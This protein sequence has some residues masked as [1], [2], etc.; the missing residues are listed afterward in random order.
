MEH[1]D[2]IYYLSA[3]SFIALILLLIHIVQIISL[4]KKLLVIKTTL[5]ILP[6]TLSIFILIKK[7][8]DDWYDTVFIIFM[9][10][11]MAYLVSRSILFCKSCGKLSQSQGTL[12]KRSKY[13]PY[14][15]NDTQHI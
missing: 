10:W 5:I 12:F 9:L 8:Y 2:L 7:S 15:G 1:S 11:G 14:C 4:E 3:F 13:C 6:L